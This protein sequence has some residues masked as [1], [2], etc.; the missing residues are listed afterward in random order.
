MEDALTPM[1]AARILILGCYV[2]AGELH[3]FARKAVARLAGGDHQAL[4]AWRKNQI[5]TRRRRFSL[6]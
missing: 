2:L 3:W 5:D 1:T 6:A 4:N